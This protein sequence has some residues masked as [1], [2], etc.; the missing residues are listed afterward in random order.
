[1]RRGLYRCGTHFANQDLV[2]AINYESPGG[3]KRM[4]DRF[5]LV[6][7]DDPEMARCIADALTAERCRCEL[8]ANGEAALAACRQYE[9]DAVVSDIRMA[10]MD[11]VELMTRLRRVQSDLPVIL[12]TAEGSIAAA[13]EAVK[14]GAYQYITKP[15]D[16]GELRRIVDQAV[17]T[18]ARAERPPPSRRA[19]PSGTEELIGDSP[20]MRELRARIELVG[21]ASSPVLVVGETGTGKELV[22]RAIHACSPR[23]SRP[24]VT[25]NAAAIPETLLESEMFG[26]VRGAFTGATQAHR[27]LLTEADGGTLLLDEIGD[28]PIGLQSKL[29]RV[30]QA[31]EIRAVGGDRIQ[32]V[33]VRIVAATHRDLRAMVADG[34]FR[35]DLWYRIA[36]FPIQ[37]PPLRDRPEDIPALATHFAL[38]AATR[39]GTPPR[40]PSPEEMELLLG[41]AWPGNVRELAAV[42]ERAVILGNG[43]TLDVAASLGAA[44]PATPAPTSERAVRTAPAAARPESPFPSLDDAIRRHIEEALLRTRGRIEGARGAAALLRIN[45]HTLRAKMRKLRIEWAQFRGEGDRPSP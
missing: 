44:I 22:A 41:Y 45:P 5:I 24:F 19:L 39:F 37:I 34:Q 9:F 32:R 40:V 27:G 30:L 2:T 17:M 35:E 28:M 23:R 14:R 10:G 18:R 43:R 11:G 4:Q 13:V 26:H 7:D 42:I 6:V 12:M 8:A 33:D 29:L 21:A 1:M 36:V 31:G 15:C 25:V 38:R 16:A 3:G 20:A